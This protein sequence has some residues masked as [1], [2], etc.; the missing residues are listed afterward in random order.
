MNATIPMPPRPHVLML[1]H[2]FYPDDPR[3]RREAETLAERG[4]RVQVIGTSRDERSSTYELNG[5]EVVETSVRKTRASLLSYLMQYWRTLIQCRRIVQETTEHSRVDLV[6]VH[7]LPDFLVFSAEPARRRGVP[8][9]LD[10]HESMSDFFA[11][12]YGRKGQLLHAALEWLERFSASRATQLLT[13]N[14]EIAD[15]FAH[16]LGR[17]PVVIMNTVDEATFGPPRTEVKWDGT[18]KTLGYH[19]T[20]SRIYGLDLL[21]AALPQIRGFAPDTELHIFG[22]G[23]ERT[24][25]EEQSKRLGV[26]DMIVFRGRVPL[27]EMATHLR[28]IDVGVVPTRKDTFL[29]M[30]LAT[31]LLEYVYLGIPV[32]CSDLRAVE[33]VFGGNSLFFF[34]GNDIGSLAET[35]SKCLGSTPAVIKARVTACQQIYEKIAWPIMADRY[36]GVVQELCSSC[37]SR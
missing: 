10:L 15:T 20:L 4:Y 7:T 31:K 30:S 13:V 11:S 34:R 21:I 24:A 29:D 14:D 18:P 19:G 9:L 1:A 22:E 23:P 8:V 12:K 36:I 27:S 6:Q 17:R 25:L 32:V 26:R 35:T 37:S 3:I 28:E 2:S 5:V 16:R 33:R